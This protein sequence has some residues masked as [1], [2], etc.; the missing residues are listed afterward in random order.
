MLR[1]GWVL[2]VA[3][4][5]SLSAG[6]EKRADY[7]NQQ[8]AQARF[9]DETK[10]ELAQIASDLEER[11]NR[12][13]I[14][15][16]P[17]IRAL[18]S[19][20]L[21][22]VDHFDSRD[23]K[24][25]PVAHHFMG[26]PGVGKSGIIEIL[27]DDLPVVRIDAQKYIEAGGDN[28]FYYALRRN[29]LLR[30]GE[31][32]ILVIEELDKVREVTLEGTEQTQP[33]IG[34]INELLNNGVIT[35]GASSTDFSHVMVIT[36]MNIPP[37]VVESF[38]REAL[39]GKK[40]FF[41]Y[42]IEDFD[43]FHRWINAKGGGAVAHML[44]KIFRPNTVGRLAPN[45]T[46]MK[47]FSASEYGDLIRLAM[48]SSLERL[49]Q[50]ANAPRWL[51][52]SYT[53][54]FID[55]FLE[56][57]VNPPLGARGVMVK[58]NDVM[59]ELVSYVMRAQIAGDKSLDRPRK[60]TLDFDRGKAHLRITPQKRGPRGELLDESPLTI[61][62]EL[63]RE[64]LSF[65]R[66][67][68]VTFDPPPSID[69]SRKVRPLSREERI[70]RERF[71]HVEQNAKGLA[72]SIG[73]KVYGQETFAQHIEE[74]MN[75]YLTADF[76]TPREPRASLLA[77]FP[78]IGKSAMIETIS[79]TLSLPIARINLQNYS[80]SSKESL[81][82]FVAALQEEVYN[83]RRAAGSDGK[84]LLVLEEI[85]KVGEIDPVTGAPQDRPV[86]T[87]IKELLDRGEISQRVRN[88][89]EG[90]V[91]HYAIDIRDA[92][93]FTTMNFN[94]KIFDFQ[95]DPRLT[96]IDDTID[97]WEKLSKSKAGLKGVLENMFRPETI[98]RFLSKM[99]VLKPLELSHY[100]QIIDEQGQRVVRLRFA[101]SELSLQMTKTYKDYLVRESVVPSEGARYTVES[102]FQL[103]S[104]DLEDAIDHLPR[105]LRGSPLKIQLRYDNKKRQVVAFAQDLTQAGIRPVEILRKKVFENFPSPKM[106]GK[107]PAE[108]IRTGAHEVGHALTAVRLGQRIDN[109]SSVS[110]R[111]GRGGHVK[112]PPR[113]INMDAHD[114]VANIY[115]VLASRA[116]ERI[117]LSPDP[118]EKRSVLHV[119]TGPSGDIEEATEML[120]RALFKLGFNPYGGTV[121][122]S[123]VLPGAGMSFSD[124]P[125]ETVEHMGE[126]LR[127]MEDFLV[128]D[129]L[130]A[131]DIEWYKDK[132]LKV[133]RAGVVSE[134][135]FFEIIEHPFPS[136]EE[137]GSLRKLSRIH[138]V[139]AGNVRDKTT[140]QTQKARDFRY[141]S[142]M[143]TVEEQLAFYVEE[144][145][146]RLARSP[147]G[148]GKG[149]GRCLQVLRRLFN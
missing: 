76:T 22:Y 33:F 8:I 25:P 12:E 10:Q 30:S 104:R 133:A 21:H 82:S 2:L 78:G 17:T 57:T 63:D 28:T 68:E 48:D 32:V 6:D 20:I 118:L 97:A 125:L 103:I 71:P 130:E 149:R 23:A 37:E 92:Y 59:E 95:A 147:L 83:A 53:D 81:E 111:P 16:R 137:E 72:R 86:I 36:T 24:Q 44:S 52:A 65:R 143:K 75:K 84:Y 1:L 55:F 43:K 56:H 138:Q 54:N 127:E 121:N 60:V 145:E 124:L 94:G 41:Q 110:L 7:R 96:T 58:V 49:T 117:V 140:A 79:E 102:A 5:L 11:I 123:G 50:N 51:Q 74:E 61:T 34:K 100:K 131:N 38:S 146:K 141:G 91:E 109:V 66:P 45:T 101:D 77:G 35:K 144:F 87:A 4:S 67:P 107:L 114:L 108:R 27:S 122:S 88:A 14:A 69:R 39:G 120:G 132:V 98:S 93:V 31:P 42:G 3:F 99:F 136:D 148:G 13:I 15:Q 18:S 116:M 90:D 126:L 40:S 9:G 115:T 47:H 80:S 119:S 29:D 89:L 85:D 112:F 135:E 62:S 46:V 64:T 106:S 113:K 19:K 139:F 129:L 26:F 105:S 128:R 70:I 142:G 73:K 134:K